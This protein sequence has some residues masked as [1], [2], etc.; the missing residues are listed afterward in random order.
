MPI[1]G[2]SC[3]TKKAVPINENLDK[4]SILNSPKA[5]SFIDGMWQ[6]EA[7]YSIDSSIIRQIN[8]VN[9]YE[10]LGIRLIDSN[11][12]FKKNYMLIDFSRSN[13]KIY[14][15]DNSD[16]SKCGINGIFSLDD[17]NNRV[18]YIYAPLAVNLQRYFFKFE[19]D[20][21]DK[22]YELN[23]H[24]CQRGECIQDYA[25]FF[26]SVLYDI[27]YYSLQGNTLVFRNKTTKDLVLTELFLK[28]LDN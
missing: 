12:I 24:N 25:S 5:S 14:S 21:L 20:F 6:I 27:N 26:A 7:C 15:M 18:N 10:K 17:T 4:T 19:R 23:I 9:G 28:R 2:I 16:T 22:H 13:L 3:F 1:F 11:I 8:G